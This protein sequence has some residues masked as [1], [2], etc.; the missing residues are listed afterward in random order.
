MKK[1]TD[2]RSPATSPGSAGASA[3][4]GIRGAALGAV[5][6]LAAAG[7]FAQ[8]GTVEHGSLDIFAA[9]GFRLAWGVLKAGAGGS[10]D[11]DAVVVRV[12]RDAASDGIPREPSLEAYGVD[13]F[14]GER[15]TLAPAAGP[16]KSRE[17]RLPRSHFADFPRTEIMFFSGPGEVGR[18]A[19]VITVY[20][21]GIP[22]T[23]PEFLDAAKLDSYLTARL[24]EAR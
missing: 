1:K 10:P 23:T 22:D 18:T 24:A 9:Q 3:G 2:A 7:L 12:V 13:P 17:L 8:K 15:K 6:L 11:D 21:V 20:F 4:A 16:G 5:L 19:P 14:G